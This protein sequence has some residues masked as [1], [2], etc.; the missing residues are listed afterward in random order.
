[1][2]RAYLIAGLLATTMFGWAQFKGYSIFGS[3]SSTHV[4]GGVG[5]GGSRIY[6]K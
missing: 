3:P 4:A 1:M 5:G 2:F 6:H